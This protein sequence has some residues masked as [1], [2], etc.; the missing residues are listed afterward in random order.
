[1]FVETGDGATNT[2]G[3][4]A[5]DEDGLYLFGEVLSMDQRKLCGAT[6][7][8]A[9]GCARAPGASPPRGSATWMIGPTR[10]SR[11]HMDG[12]SG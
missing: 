3:D 4:E 9:G 7:G 5:K 2:A 6:G 8:V 12:V 11:W 1:M 10:T